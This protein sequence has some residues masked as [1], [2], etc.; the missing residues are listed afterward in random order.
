MISVVHV[1]HVPAKAR[2]ENS[3]E[4]FRRSTNTFALLIFAS[5]CSHK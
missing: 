5:A 2:E 4:I 3:L 1:S